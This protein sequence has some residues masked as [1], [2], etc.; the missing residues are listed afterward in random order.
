M[1]VGMIEHGG[2][3][4]LQPREHHALVFGMI[5]PA[6]H[7]IISRRHARAFG[8]DAEF[9][10]SLEPPLTLFVPTVRKMRVVVADE[11]GRR[12]MRRMASAEREPAKPRV[13]RPVRDMIGN[14]TD[15]AVHEIGGQMIAALERAGRLDMRIVEHEFRR[16]L[17]RLRIQKP[18]ETIEAARE[19]PAIERPCRAAL[20]QRRHVPLADH[21]IAIAV[22][23]QHFGERARLLRDLP[24]IARKAG[25][26]IGEAP[27]ADRMMVAPGQQR[28][29]RRRTHGGRMETGVTQP[30]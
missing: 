28:R 3:G 16:V 8:H 9:F 20:R 23:T 14:E 26:E 11:I 18:V 2:I 15:R 19:R 29:A 6:A 21:V 22:R 5:G 13:L 1:L 24:A 4:A 12:L 17:I 25:I 10:L 30:L 27:H 7:K